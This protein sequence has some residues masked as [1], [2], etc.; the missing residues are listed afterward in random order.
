MPAFFGFAGI[1]AHVNRADLLTYFIAAVWLGNGLFAKVLDLVPRH[2]MIVGRI[3]GE[4]HS[5][6]ITVLIGTAE[7]IMAVWIVTGILPMI[8]SLVQVTVIAAMNIIEFLLVRDLLLFGKLN[9]LV[10]LLFITIVLW[11]GFAAA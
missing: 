7:I 11:R 6:L 2:R 4:R 1:I 9:A 8:N 5:R 10:A 3:V